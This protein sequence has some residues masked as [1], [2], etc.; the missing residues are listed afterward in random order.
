MQANLTFSV[1][2]TWLPGDAL[3]SDIS[4][5]NMSTKGEKAEVKKKK[6]KKEEEVMS[7]MDN[8]QPGDSISNIDSFSNFS[9]RW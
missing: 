6:E 1:Q 5:S 4:Q 8:V 7:A 3:T 9:R 2:S